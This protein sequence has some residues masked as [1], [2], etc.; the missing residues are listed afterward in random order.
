MCDPLEQ[1]GERRIDDARAGRL[2]VAVGAEIE[3]AAFGLLREHV[4]PPAFGARLQPRRRDEA[5]AGEPDRRREQI[6]PGEAAM[7]LMRER[8]EPEVAGDADAEPARNSLA[9]LHRLA[10]RPVEAGGG[11][12]CGRGL[13][14]VVAGEVPG[15][16]IV[17]EHEA[18]AADARAL[19][20]D[21]GQRDHH[22]DR[23]VG[24]AAAA[25]QY[26]E[27][28][29]GRARIGGRNR[30]ALRGGRRR[31][32]RRLGRA[33][34]EREGERK[35]QA[36]EHQRGFSVPIASVKRS[37]PSR[38]SKRLSARLIRFARPGPS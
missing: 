12:R 33:G 26:F 2:G 30:A 29:L 3:R 25:A 16:G 36:A 6:G 14:A 23:R 20:L 11:G 10:V 5:V 8:G 15:R 7:L 32:L 35:E 21:H 31:R 19:R 38:A 28:R 17:I 13:A 22:R 1:G 34:G 18:A 9:M 24:G 4:H 37:N 27:P